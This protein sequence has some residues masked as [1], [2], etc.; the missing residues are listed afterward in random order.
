MIRASYRVTDH[1]PQEKHA[2]DHKQSFAFSPE[3]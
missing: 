2:N 1:P 3:L